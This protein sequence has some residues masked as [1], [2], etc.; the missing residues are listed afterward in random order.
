MIT[1]YFYITLIY[2]FPYLGK[3]YQIAFMRILW[4]FYLE[5]KCFVLLIEVRVNIKRKL[6]FRGYECMCEHCLFIDV[7][8][9][10]RVGLS[11]YKG[12]Y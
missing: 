9:E 3:Y 6:G 2:I 5:C 12:L 7:Y 4:D 1:A 11:C 10:P 8:L